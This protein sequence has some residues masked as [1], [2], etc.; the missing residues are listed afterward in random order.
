MKRPYQCTIGDGGSVRTVHAH[1]A[2]EAA[3]AIVERRNNDSAE[4]PEDDATVTVYVLSPGDTITA[5]E[6]RASYRIDYTAETVETDP[7][8]DVVALLRGRA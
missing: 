8:A 6:V 1:D 4:Y 2:D 7:P 5:H 3:E